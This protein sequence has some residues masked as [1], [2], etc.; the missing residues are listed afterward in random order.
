MG[1]GDDLALASRP[2]HRGSGCHECRRRKLKCSGTK[3]ACD[4]CVRSN[5]QCVYDPVEKSKVALLRDEVVMLRQKVKSLEAQ[6]TPPSP[7]TTCSRP[8]SYEPSSRVQTSSPTPPAMWRAPLS[9]DEQSFLLNQFLGIQHVANEYVSF[10]SHQDL[11]AAKMSAYLLASHFSPSTPSHPFLEWSRHSI[12]ES[13]RIAG[14]TQ[15]NHSAPLVLDA[16]HASSLLASWMMINGRL[17]ECQQALFSAAKLA[18]L[19]GLHKI[20]SF[21]LDVPTTSAPPSMVSAPT[22]TADAKYR[23]G[24]FWQLLCLDYTAAII[25]G[26]SVSASLPW[27]EAP[28]EV[29][30]ET[31]WPAFETGSPSK[32]NPG[33]IA[34]LFKSSQTRAPSPKP[35]GPVDVG[36]LRAKAIVL[37]ERAVRVS[38]LWRRSSRSSTP[39][40][41]GSPRSPSPD[42]E[43]IRKAIK[44]TDWA[45]SSVLEQL[46]LGS[47]MKSVCIVPHTLLLCARVRLHETLAEEN[48][49]VSQVVWVQSAVAI[50]RLLDGVQVECPDLLLAYSWLA[51]HMV[52]LHEHT[53][54]PY[55]PESEHA[56]RI[57][58]DLDKLRRLLEGLGKKMPI[59]AT[60]YKSAVEQ[61]E[62]QRRSTMKVEDVK[63]EISN[64]EVDELAEDT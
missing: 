1:P 21:T 30:V 18:I 7:S 34:S 36:V 3:P 2:L 49:P 25:M 16:I 6:I 10:A 27:E 44:E 41:P 63:M 9:A 12:D 55:H 19:S 48:D 17:L 39:T 23:V 20:R 43:A 46:P 22:S 14:Q 61:F 8:S 32:A 15:P 45:I 42:N 31:M 57:R 60:M 24:V 13:I 38:A 33:S 51:S 28:A 56:I 5:T 64:A 52:L 11:P 62:A 53:Y 29:L 37:L 58:A 35:S 47:E 50:V 40:S 54:V 26:P 59:V 4:R